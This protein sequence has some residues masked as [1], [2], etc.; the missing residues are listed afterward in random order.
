MAKVRVQI[1]NWDILDVGTAKLI[2]ECEDE[3][4][5]LTASHEAYMA[6]L[7]KRFGLPPVRRWG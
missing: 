3:E 5:H 2:F 4:I 6:I 1:D 7:R